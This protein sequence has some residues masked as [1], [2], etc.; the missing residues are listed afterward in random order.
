[1]LYA[2]LGRTKA[3]AP[4]V[5]PGTCHLDS[6]RYFTASNRS[7][8]LPA[9]GLRGM[10][11]LMVVLGHVYAAAG[12]PYLA[13]GAVAGT[14]D[15]MH[16]GVDLFFV[17]SGF[18]LYYPLTR[19]GSRRDWREFFRRRARRLLPPYYVAVAAVIL[20]PFVVAPV[21][22]T[23]G[24]VVVPA[25]WP[26]WHQVWTHL[27]LIHTFSTD[28][29]YGLNGP[30]WSLG[31][32]IQFY[33]AF[34]LAVWI[35]HRWGWRGVCLIGAIALAYRMAVISGTLFIYQPVD[36]PDIFLSRWLAFALGML[37]ALQVRHAPQV[38]HDFRR[39]MSD[40]GGA[41]CLFLLAAY[42]LYGPARQ[43]PYP[44]KD[45]L[46]AGLYSVVLYTA[47]SS[48]SFIGGLLAHRVPVW[49]GR[50][51]YSLYLVHLPI[52]FSLGPSVMAWH[53]GLLTGLLA[54][55]A[56]CVPIALAGAALF[57]HLFERP[58]LNPPRTEPAAAVVVPA[59]RQERQRSAAASAAASYGDTG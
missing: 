46:F 34:P 5:P 57:F 36:V 51:S 32:E 40:L 4:L 3:C 44:P 12:Y 37:V 6:G 28:T 56:V 11:A 2:F 47:C 53:L 16:S 9:D 41:I 27:F 50:I 15:F 29:F 38:R 54:M 26:S 48:G 13:I 52:V 39:E 14:L 49:L 55:T 8:L 58:F 10:A 31:I 21:A 33:L 1:M 42:L 59:P 45:V 24:L 43:W 18:C 7:H 25:T 22:R 23:L 30:F 19:A 17:L 35:V 20:L